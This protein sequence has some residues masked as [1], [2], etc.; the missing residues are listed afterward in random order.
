MLGITMR[1]MRHVYP[2]GAVEERDALARDWPRFLAQILPDEPLFPL[3]NL[4]AEIP[5]YVA[6]LGL[7]GLIFSGG[8]DWGLCPERDATEAA[9]FAWAQEGGVP[10]FGVCRGA[11][12][13]NLLLGGQLD[14]CEGHVAVRHDAALAR[15][16][17]GRP[18]PTVNSFHAQAILPQGL[19]PGLGAFALAPD[20]TVEAYA[21]DHGRIIGVMWHPE[22]EKEPA[23]LDVAVLR[24]WLARGTETL[25]PT[26]DNGHE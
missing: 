7:S 22:R 12:V 17:A 14:S 18:R 19:A 5:E 10:V 26:G 8:E 4:G 11:Q 23:P 9:L 15:P 6:R 20:G 24:A 2:G 13:I 16:I 3:P 25:L 21:G 1:V